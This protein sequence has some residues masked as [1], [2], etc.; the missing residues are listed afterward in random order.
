MEFLGSF[1]KIM[2]AGS[3]ENDEFGFPASS[4]SGTESQHSGT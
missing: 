4:N 3:T 2:G 1:I